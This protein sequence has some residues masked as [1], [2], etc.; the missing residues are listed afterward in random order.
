MMNV[1]RMEMFTH[2]I[3]GAVRAGDDNDIVLIN[4]V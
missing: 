3:V 4:V 1:N 2:E